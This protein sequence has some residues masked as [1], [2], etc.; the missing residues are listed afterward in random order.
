MLGD[1]KT[2]PTRKTVRP[3][4]DLAVEWLRV[5][6]QSG[7]GEGRGKDGVLF[8][9]ACGEFRGPW[10]SSLLVSRFPAD[11]PRRGSMDWADTEVGVVEGLE[12]FGSA[13][14]EE[15]ALSRGVAGGCLHPERACPW[16]KVPPASKLRKLVTSNPGLGRCRSPHPSSTTRLPDLAAGCGRAWGPG[17]ESPGTSRLEVWRVSFPIFSFRILREGRWRIRMNWIGCRVAQNWNLP[18]ESGGAGRDC[19]VVSFFGTSLQ[20]CPPAS[21]VRTVSNINKP[22]TNIPSLRSAA[23]GTD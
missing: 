4:G 16:A 5:G 21:A 15:L 14:S 3:S 12:Q 9:E 23:D 2:H 13:A 6:L 22:G 8:Q 18:E 20:R 1:Y 10:P 19:S 17:L 7:G 11:Q